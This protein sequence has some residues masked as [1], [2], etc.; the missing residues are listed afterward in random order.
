MQIVTNEK[1]VRRRASI[2]KWASLLGFAGLAGG[3]IISLLMSGSADQPSYTLTILVA[4][5]SL[6][7]GLIGVNIGRYN[8]SRWGRHP[9]E[10]EVLANNMKGLD[11]KYVLYNYQEHLP[12][13][14]LMLTPFGLVV[15]E[16]RPQY[17]QI[18]NTGHRWRRRGGGWAILQMIAEGGIGN[19]TRDAQRAAESVRR[20]LSST[21]SEEEAAQV[22]VEPAIVFT[23][24]LARVEAEDPEVPV[25]HPKDLRTFL[26]ATAGRTKLSHE[27]YRKLSRLLPAPAAAK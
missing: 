23:N 9:T 5:G 6:M 18:Y 25:V 19:P 22:P 7:I 17:G 20:M 24:S 12:V 26:R 11:Y 2:A 3:F 10:H 13:D 21:L 1:F 14:H 15:L 8:N 4:Y 16:T 27:L